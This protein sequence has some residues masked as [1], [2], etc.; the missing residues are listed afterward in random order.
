MKID[1]IT[2]WLTLGANIGVV[3]GLA[4]LVLE[5]RQNA[6]LSRASLETEKNSLLTQIELSLATPENAAV[7]VKSIRHPEEMTDAEIRMME[8]Y[9][10]SIMLQWDQ[11]FVMETSGLAGRERLERHVSNTAPYYFGSAFAK[12]WWRFQAPGWEGTPM[13]EIADPIIASLDENFLKNNLDNMRIG[14][15]N[16]NGEETDE[17]VSSAVTLN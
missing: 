15:K 2:T 17:S 13:S 9:L 8:A 6:D 12:N 16:K 11:V 4:I 14:G 1:R 7:W 5:L 3:V 10:V